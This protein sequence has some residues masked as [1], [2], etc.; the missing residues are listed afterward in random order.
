MGCIMMDKTIAKQVSE[1]YGPKFPFPCQVTRFNFLQVVSICIS[2]KWYF[3]QIGIFKHLV[4]FYAYVCM[5]MLIFLSCIHQV[6][7][8]V[9]L[10]GFILNPWSKPTWFKIVQEHGTQLV[11]QIVYLICAKV[12]IVDNLSQISSLKMIRTFM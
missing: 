12:Q 6:Y 1:Y 8:M 3:L 11:F 2:N 5:C 4:T 10:L 9:G 7:L